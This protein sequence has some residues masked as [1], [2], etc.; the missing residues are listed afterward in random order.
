MSWFGMRSMLALVEKKMSAI[1]ARQAF[2]AMKLPTAQWRCGD[3]LA[4]PGGPYLACGLPLPVKTKMNER[5][6]EFKPSTHFPF[7]R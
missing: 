7:T 4:Q 3:F 5:E 6:Y 2:A 1:L